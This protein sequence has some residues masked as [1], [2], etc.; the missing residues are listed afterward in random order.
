MN[1]LASTKGRLAAF[2][3]L[4]VTEGLPLGFAAGAIAVYMRRE[5]VSFDDMGWFLGM[6]YFPWG[7]KWVAGPVVD[8]LGSKRLGHRRGWIL[9]AQ[10]VMFLGLLGSSL[11][12][13][14]TQLVLFT[15]VMVAVN[16]FCALQDVAIDA[17]AVSSLRDE[18]RGIGNGLMFAG[19][20]IGQALGGSGMLYLA[21][22]TGSLNAAFYAVAGM[23]GG[24]WGTTFLFMR[25]PEG[26]T[27]M[28]NE[29]TAR[30]VARAVSDY[31]RTGWNA[32]IKSRATVAAGVFA[33]LPAS[34]MALGLAL[35]AALAVEVGLS[36][37]QI[38][39]MGLIGAVAAASGSVAGGWI[40][41]RTGHRKTLAVYILLTLIPT[42]SLAVVMQQNGW[43]LPID[44]GSPDARVP[45]EIVVS[46]FWYGTIVY[47]FF[48][49]LTYGTRM[50]IF[51][52]VCDPKIAATQFTAYMAASNMAISY[53]SYWQGATVER[54]GYP[55]TLAIDCVAGL[56]C[57][58]VL[59]LITPRDDASSEPP[60]SEPALRS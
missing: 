20:Y 36:D 23:V 35:Q 4:Y 21:G 52:K 38:A 26:E 53:S 19:A 44:P 39:T 13:Y 31:A 6:L 42:A 43:I 54:W 55:T 7:F 46:T 37:D 58:A 47:G 8:L 59:P 57:L 1:L 25:E 16:S 33:L 60:I 50:A 45:S 9:F 56:A 17:L 48:S 24:V 30:E 22:S 34:A 3:L 5:G 11:V 18:E 41:D 32:V 51:M 10:A 49:G 28:L 40:S 29:P 14:S 27:S 12:D 2:F 15:A